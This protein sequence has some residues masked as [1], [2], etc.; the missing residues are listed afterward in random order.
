M[1]GSK[2]PPI[3]DAIVDVVLAYKPKAKTDSAKKRK[4]KIK[5]LIKEASKPLGIAPKAH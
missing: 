2:P 5:K 4:K 3:L 1:S